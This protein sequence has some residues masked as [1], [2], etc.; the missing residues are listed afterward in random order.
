M[1]DGDSMMSN[2][3]DLQAAKHALLI[4]LLEKEGIESHHSQKIFPRQCSDNTP[5]SFSQERLWFLDQ[6]E[7]GNT[8]YNICRA[9]RLAGQLNLSALTQSLNEVVRRHEILRTTFPVVND[10]PVQLVTPTLTLTIPVLDL[11]KS[12]QLQPGS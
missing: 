2:K 10:H 7:P 11:K 5:L 6:L 12:S 4:S 1:A 8:V 3:L 9:Q